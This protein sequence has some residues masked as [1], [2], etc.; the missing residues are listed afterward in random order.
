MLEAPPPSSRA[1]RTDTPCA[2]TLFRYSLSWPVISLC[3]SGPEHQMA[4]AFFRVTK[5]KSVPEELPFE[6]LSF[7]FPLKRNGYSI[8]MLG[9]PL[10]VLREEVSAAAFTPLALV[11]PGNQGFLISNAPLPLLFR[12]SPAG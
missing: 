5:R 6:T 9:L 1:D 8:S 2:P 11:V 3:V 7:L 10:S 12:L 4:P